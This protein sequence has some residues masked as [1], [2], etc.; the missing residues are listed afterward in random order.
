M[1]ARHLGDRADRA[2]PVLGQPGHVRPLSAT[3]LLAL[4]EDGARRPPLERALCVLARA[5]GRQHRAGLAALSIGQRDALLLAVRARTFGPRLEGSTACPACAAAVEAGVDLDML[6]GLEPS[7][8]ASGP[9]RLTA[10]WGEWT[11]R[12]RSPTTEDLL[13]LAASGGDPPSPRRL[14]D[15][16]IEWAE[17]GGRP[18]E[19]GEVPGPARAVAEDRLAE[20]DPLAVVEL[21]L[22]CPECGH[23]WRTLLDIGHFLWNE[24]DAAAGRLLREV[25]ALAT[26]YGWSEQDI[27]ALSPA[28]RRAYL[29]LAL[30]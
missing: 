22:V 18:A 9:R 8:P 5:L 26:A 6:R 20:A 17:R 29:E 2:T 25:H 4:W 30:A 16:C 7:S 10:S 3:D 24:I 28:R 27:L 1:G 19:A 15:R 14:L 11:L 21:E 23:A 13:A 12:L